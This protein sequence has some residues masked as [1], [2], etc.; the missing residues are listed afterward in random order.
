MQ[1]LALD[2]PAVVLEDPDYENTNLKDP[3]RPGTKMGTVEVA[4]EVIQNGAFQASIL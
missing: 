2:Q 1:T 4:P 3:S